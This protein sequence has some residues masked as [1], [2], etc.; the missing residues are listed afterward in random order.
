MRGPNRGPL[1][2]HD[3]DKAIHVDAL[4]S[5]DD[6]QTDERCELMVRY[7]APL[8]GCGVMML[9]CR[10]LMSMGGRHRGPATTDA[11]PDE[12]QALRDEVARLR[13]VVDAP[14]HVPDHRG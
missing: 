4:P 1:R 14:A 9:I 10:A 6:V 7:L 12:V 8:V 11:A 5:L 13:T 3:A 2:H